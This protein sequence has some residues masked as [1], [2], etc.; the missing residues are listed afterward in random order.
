MERK[1]PFCVIS[2]D[3]LLSLDRWVPHQVLLKRG[4]LLDLSDGEMDAD[5]AFVSHQWTGFGH[6]DPSGA[7]LRHLQRVV[8]RL[9]NGELDVNNNVIL[10]LIY[11]FQSC[12]TAEEW[13]EKLGGGGFYFWID[14]LSIPQ[15]T[16][17][18]EQ[19]AA[20][21]PTMAAPPPGHAGGLDKAA[22]LTR[23]ASSDHRLLA[24]P[25]AAQ[26]TDAVDS[27]PS[28]ITACSEMWVLT[29]PVVHCDEVDVCCD[30]NSWRTRGWCRMEFAA[31]KLATGEDKPVMLIGA[32]Q[33]QAQNDEGLE[34]FQPCDIVK[35][36]AHQGT[37]T[38]DSDRPKVSAIIKAML[39]SKL[40]AYEKSANYTLLR[41]LLAFAPVFIPK[42]DVADL[43]RKARRPSTADG[44][45]GGGGG[46]GAS[47]VEELK[48]RVRWRG[49]VAE[50]AWEQASGWSLLTLAAALDDLPAVEALLKR[51]DAGEMLRARGKA[52]SVPGHET[53]NKILH[54]YSTNMTPL[55]AA[56]TLASP[57]VL[58]ALLDAGADIKADAAYVFGEDACH[59]RGC[60]IAG[61]VEN[62]RYLLTRFPEYVSSV[63]S[64][65]GF[66]PLNFAFEAG[67]NQYEMVEML[68]SLGADVNHRASMGFTVTQF[69]AMMF[70]VDP[71]VIALLKGAGADL[72]A[73]FQA[74]PGP[75]AL[76]SSPPRA[77]CLRPPLPHALAPALSS[78]HLARHRSPPFDS[79]VQQA[80]ADAHDDRRTRP[81]LGPQRLETA[82]GGALRAAQDGRQL[83]CDGGRHR[84][85]RR[86]RADRPAAGQGAARGGRRPDG[87]R[88]CGADGAR[89]HQ[90]AA[91]RRR[92]G[93][94][95]LRAC[96]RP[97]PES[98]G[99]A[100]RAARRRALRRRR[101]RRRARWA[102][103]L[104]VSAIVGG[105]VMVARSRR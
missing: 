55:V 28:F 45:G 37:F 16:A 23:Q 69:G 60:V 76:Q 22:A 6:P 103:L 94:G 78:P 12:R 26:L 102:L 72:G 59:M 53:F 58:A 11:G 47:A 54:D 44:G 17:E 29:P 68:L 41:L 101:R 90:G 89:C 9:R 92:D 31:S 81:R 18:G 24:T 20:W 64:F 50:A 7:Q 56:A 99:R 77:R 39:T 104:V 1:Y 57:P 27:I 32:A 36:S 34:Y 79:A 3:T 19:P 49:D 82:Q 4:E 95:P 30:F 93:D 61:R 33:C 66:C 25:L 63:P 86:R 71:R 67:F 88:R 38:Q 62:A 40:D 35:L 15:P 2:V 98:T 74:R 21:E 84:A 65:A 43:M 80:A 8:R 73:R 105:A 51:A 13:A 52:H 42:A 14:Y 70:D 83:Q 100:P 85:A 96:T 91:R 97:R 87:A 5:V 46:G 10:E 75:P 48:R